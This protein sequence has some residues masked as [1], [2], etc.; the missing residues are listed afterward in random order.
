[1][2]QF[3][4]VNAQQ[5]GRRMGNQVIFLLDSH[6][7]T[8]CKFSVKDSFAFASATLSISNIPLAMTQRSHPDEERSGDLYNIIHDY[9]ISWPS[10]ETF[11]T[12]S[13]IIKEVDSCNWGNMPDSLLRILS[14]ITFIASRP[15]SSDCCPTLVI[16]GV[17]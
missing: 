17:M 12:E 5:H 16:L 10:S 11:L 8:D 9:N 3:F 2:N 13:L 7:L 6:F 15:I 4:R 1:M 14:I